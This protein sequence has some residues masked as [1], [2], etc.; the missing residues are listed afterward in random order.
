VCVIIPV[1]LPRRIRSAPHLWVIAAALLSGGTVLAGEIEVET[2]DG[3]TVRGIY[4]GVA[5]GGFLQVGER[6]EVRSLR[7]DELSRIT[8]GAEIQ[9]ADPPPDATIFYLSPEGRCTG[10]LLAEVDGGIQVRT[11]FAASAVLRFEHLAAIRFGAGSVGG[12]A[13]EVFEAELSKRLPGTDVLVAQ[14]GRRVTTVRGTLVALGPQRGR[15]LFKGRQHGLEV[16]RTY[17]VVLAS[18]NSE[19]RITNRE[20]NTAW[21]PLILV[22]L[23]GGSRL[24]GWLRPC[25]AQQVVVDSVF[26]SRLELAPDQVVDITFRSD[27]VVY[28]SD[29]EPVGQ[30][31]RGLLHG[32]WPIQKDRSVANKPIRLAGRRFEKGIGVHARTQL[33]YALQEKFERFCATIGIDDSV[34]PRGS[35]V[36]RVSGDGR[37]LFDSGPVGGRDEPRDL[38]LDVTGVNELTLLVDYGEQMDLADH[39]DWAN[40]RAIRIA[41]GE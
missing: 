15:F 3:R 27:R 21:G 19:L 41:N 1:G 24:P 14:S 29:T 31:T 32:P 6:P 11:G 17:G 38:R 8:F 25:D 18:A 37:L 12:S 33:V 13:R 36:F 20:F 30:Q 9:P 2:I 35:V 4:G 40:A 22:H 5:D 39:A 16:A 34:R 28:L 26:G 10:R 23:C 7:L